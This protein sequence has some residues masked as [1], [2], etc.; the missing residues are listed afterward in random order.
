MTHIQRNHRHSAHG[1]LQQWELD[2][3]RVIAHLAFGDRRELPTGCHLPR[4]RPID[5]H[6][7]QRSLERIDIGNRDTGYTAAVGESKDEYSF[8]FRSLQMA[9]SRRGNRARVIQARMRNDKCQRARQQARA[10]PLPRTIEEPVEE[11]LQLSAPP[12]IPRARKWCCV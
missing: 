2:L 8:G 1:L 6:F 5:F 7:T 10:G 4:G 11:R 3:N 12:W 9:V